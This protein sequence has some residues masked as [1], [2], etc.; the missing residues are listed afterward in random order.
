MI[1][2]PIVTILDKLYGSNTPSKVEETYSRLIN[3][4]N[5]QLNFVGTTERKWIQ[6]DIFGEDEIIALNVLDREIGLAPRSIKKIRKFSILKGKIVFSKKMQSFR[7]NY[8]KVN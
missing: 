4:L 2:I 1:L 8:Y 6:L 7:K 5:V 3:G